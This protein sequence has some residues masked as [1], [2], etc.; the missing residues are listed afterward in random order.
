MICGIGVDIV[1]VKR[2][3]KWIN[4]PKML[5]RYF[6]PAEIMDSNQNQSI[7]QK[8]IEHYGARFAAK[9]AFGKALGTGIFGFNLTDI[10]VQNEK[11]GK[12]V[13]KVENTAEKKLKE[14]FGECKIHL[15]LSHE[16]DN[17]IAFVII[18]KE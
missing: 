13:L 18:E 14:M 6:N 15:S 3:E 4:N 9:E 17:A 2:F 12:P 16:K 11:S 5:E 8:L 1:Q 10:Y 7:S